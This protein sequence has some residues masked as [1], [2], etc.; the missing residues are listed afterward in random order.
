MTKI[1]EWRKG[2]GGMEEHEEIGKTRKTGVQDALMKLVNEPGGEAL[3]DALI[4]QRPL[5]IFGA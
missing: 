1:E 4:A 5:V 3:W 2:A